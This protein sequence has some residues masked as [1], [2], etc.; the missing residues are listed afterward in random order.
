MQD[1]FPFNIHLRTTQPCNN[2]QPTE[3]LD[4]EDQSSRKWTRSQCDVQEKP[5]QCGLPLYFELRNWSCKHISNCILWI[6]DRLQFAGLPAPRRLQRA[7]G[8]LERLIHRS[9]ATKTG[10]VILLSDF[11]TVLKLRRMKMC[12]QEYIALKLWSKWKCT[13]LCITLNVSWLVGFNENGFV[14][15]FGSEWKLLC[16]GEN[17]METERILKRSGLVWVKI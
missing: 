11:E 2:V 15:I 3:H 13:Y 1:R 10:K 7:S 8:T 17:E 14:T 4:Q 9:T 6:V 5:M 16:V 12:T